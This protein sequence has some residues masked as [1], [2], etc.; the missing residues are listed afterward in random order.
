MGM[1]LKRAKAEEIRWSFKGRGLG[2][3]ILFY[4]YFWFKKGRF[5]CDLLHTGNLMVYTLIILMF[6]IFGV[7]MY[8]GIGIGTGM[9]R[10]STSTRQDKYRTG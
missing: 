6:V 1:G 2:V 8:C 4:F 7:D 5:F 3:F 9:V 10:Y